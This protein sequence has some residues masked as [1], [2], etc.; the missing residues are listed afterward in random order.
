MPLAPEDPWAGYERLVVEIRRAHGDRLV[1]RGAPPGDVGA[2]PWASPQ[3][4]FV[5]T[6]WDPG[7]A[8]PG[9][10]PDVN[11][12]RQVALETD[13]MALVDAMW[14]ALGVDPETGT[15]DEG[16]AV[17]GLSEAHVLGLGLRY[18]QDAVFAW[19]PG[20]WAIL[21]CSGARRVTSGWRLERTLPR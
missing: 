18:G 8:R 16:V 2:W 11:R 20:S 19:T 1:V 13:L 17:Q 6:A 14:P 3:P 9:L 21:A 10:E 15:S 4:V 5:L 7:G 12:R